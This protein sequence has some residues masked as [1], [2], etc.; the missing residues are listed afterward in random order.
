MTNEENRN[1]Q[2]LLAEMVKHRRAER[3]SFGFALAF[4]GFAT[5]LFFSVFLGLLLILVGGILFLA[6]LD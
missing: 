5:M 1:I 3:R 4:I 2:K 6:N